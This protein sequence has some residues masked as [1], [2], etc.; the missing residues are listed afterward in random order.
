MPAVLELEKNSG[1]AALWP[2]TKHKSSRL[3]AEACEALGQGTAAGSMEALQK[4]LT[5]DKSPLVRGF[6]VLS[7]VRMAMDGRAQNREDI[8]GFLAERYEL[9][10]SEWVN[11]ILLEG[12]IRLGDLSL[13]PELETRL[14]HPEYRIRLMAAAAM[15]VLP[16]VFP[17]LRN[18][19]RGLLERARPKEKHP[20]VRGKIDEILGRPL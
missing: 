10:A 5:K 16:M 3:R 9:D 13:F 20:E 6:A 15:G 8:A 14:C 19:A 18:E 11:T 7:L 17:A 12:M 2:L 1:E 4:V